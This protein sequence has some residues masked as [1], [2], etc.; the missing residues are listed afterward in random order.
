MKQNNDKLFKTKEM[1]IF[2]KLSCPSRCVGR[3][4]NCLKFKKPGNQIKQVI[5]D[6]LYFFGLISIRTKS[7]WEFMNFFFRVNRVFD[8]KLACVP[9]HAG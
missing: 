6:S 2:F 5:I 4:I 8:V 7:N 9:K 1:Y 3:D